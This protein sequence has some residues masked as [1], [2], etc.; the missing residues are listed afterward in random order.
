VAFINV[1][2]EKNITGVH[3][4]TKQ[5]LWLILRSVSASCFEFKQLKHAFYS[6][7]SLVCE[8]RKEV[9][10][11]YCLLNTHFAFSICSN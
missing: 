1:H 11:R 2:L 10:I 8:I 7:L 5:W 4:E 3:L 6:G 9:I